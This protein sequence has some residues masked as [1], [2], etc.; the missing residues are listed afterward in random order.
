M[1]KFVEPL[2]LVD[3][4]VEVHG[5]PGL[6]DAG[7]QRECNL[8]FETRRQET[9]MYVDYIPV[10]RRTRGQQPTAMF[11]WLTSIYMCDV[12]PLVYRGAHKMFVI[13]VLA[14][15]NGEKNDGGRISL[16]NI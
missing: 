11:L 16:A 2:T 8:K 9:D 7:N 4:L 14:K 1:G 13:T 5:G 15:E 6:V 3:I 12:V 10:I